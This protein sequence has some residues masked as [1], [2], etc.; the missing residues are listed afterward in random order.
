MLLSRLV[1][2]VCVL[3]GFE[4]SRVQIGVHIT[5]YGELFQN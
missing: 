2:V 3:V 4:G 1:F 5:F